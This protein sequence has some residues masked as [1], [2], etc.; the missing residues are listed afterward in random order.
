MHKI[1][2]CRVALFVAVA[3]APAETN[4]EQQ[5]GSKSQLTTH[6]KRT[7][8]IEGTVIY[9]ADFERPWRYARHYVKDRNQGH[10]AEAVVALVAPRL[11]ESDTP[12]RPRTSVIDQ[13]NFNF[14]PETLAIRVGDRVKFKNSDQ[15]I[16][17]VNSFVLGNEFNVNMP[18]G[19]E[20]VETFTSAGGIGRPVTIGCIYHS[21]MHAWV[22]VFSHPFY[23]VTKSN[24]RFCFSDVPSG[25]YKLVMIHPAG[26]LNWNQPIEIEAGEQLPVDITVSPDNKVKSIRFRKSKG[27]QKTQHDMEKNHD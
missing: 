19:G 18:A 11:H 6:I 14:I 7:T 25:K 27:S 4:A 23:Q 8:T 5:P 15:V 17:N 3:F 21:A 10:L 22:Y 12:Q 16:H 2:Q 9:K 26:K 1:F 13:A 20:H 24:G